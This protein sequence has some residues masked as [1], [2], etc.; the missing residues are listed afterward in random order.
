MINSYI[1]DNGIGIDFSTS[2]TNQILKNKTIINN[3]NPGID[4]KGSSHIKIFDCNISGNGGNGGISSQTPVQYIHINNTL[5]SDNT[6]HGCSFYGAEDMI[7]SNSTI[8]NNNADG[9]NFNTSSNWGDFVVNNLIENT[10]KKATFSLIRLMKK[11]SSVV[12]IS[13]QL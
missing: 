8:I 3:N 4:L 13:K 9:I 12:L 6:A 11:I 7:I 1:A 10:P 2:T 5:I